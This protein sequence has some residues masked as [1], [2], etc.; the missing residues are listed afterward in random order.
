MTDPNHRWLQRYQPGLRLL[1]RRKG[2]SLH[3]L[4][5][6]AGRS[7][8]GEI[9]LASPQ[10]FNPDDSVAV[11]LEV[12]QNGYR[13]GAEAIEERG[14]KRILEDPSL[15]ARLVLD[16]F[17]TGCPLDLPDWQSPDL[18]IVHRPTLCREESGSAWRLAEEI[19]CAERRYFGLNEK[20][21]WEIQRVPEEEVPSNEQ[22]TL[23]Q[24]DFPTRLRSKPF[25]WTAGE[26]RTTGAAR[27]EFRM[28]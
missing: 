16:H 22:G 3:L 15:S 7:K 8:W 5:R 13:M 1:V 11:T 9:A 23:V 24:R 26:S 14:L 6:D 21:E 12:F 19:P 2:G 27:A 25:A 20:G 17:E 10:S 18:F 28:R 4:R